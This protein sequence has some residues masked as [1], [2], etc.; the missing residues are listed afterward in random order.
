VEPDKSLDKK[1]LLSFF[2]NRL[3][4]YKENPMKGEERKAI[5][6]RVQ[7]DMTRSFFNLVWKTMFASAGEIVLRPMGQRKIEKRKE[8]QERKEERNTGKK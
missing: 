2:A 1:G 5:S 4:V 3:L 6:V 8:R 7:R